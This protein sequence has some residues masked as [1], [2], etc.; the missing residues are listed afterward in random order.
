MPVD[1]TTKSEEMNFAAHLKPSDLRE[2]T[3]SYRDRLEDSAVE[4]ILALSTAFRRDNLINSE[5]NERV[6]YLF[7]KKRKKEAC[8]LLFGKV[9]TSG[10]NE[11]RNFWEIMER[12][13]KLNAT[14]NALINEIKRTAAGRCGVIRNMADDHDTKLKENTEYEE[15]TADNEKSRAAEDKHGAC[16]ERARDDIEI[17]NQ[18]PATDRRDEKSGTSQDGR[19]IGEVKEHH[20]TGNDLDRNKQQHMAVKEDGVDSSK[21]GGPDDVHSADNEGRCGVIR[22]MAGDADTELKEN[23]ENEED[24]VDNEKPRAAKAKDGA[25]TERA[26]EDI[27]ITNQ[28]PA[29]D[30]RDEKSGTSQD[31][32]NIGGRCG[33]IRKMADDPDT[34]LKENTE[35]EEDTVDNEKPRAA[36][37]KGGAGTER[38]REDI[39]I[40]NQVPA[41]E[42]RD[43]KSG[44]S[45]D[46]RTI[47]EVKEHYETGNDLDRTKLQHMAVKEDGADSSKSG[48]PEDVHSA[49]IEERCGVIR[50]MADDPNTEL[51]ENTENEEDTVDNEKPR[52]AKAKDGADTER[53][54]ED[55]EIT[56]QESGTD[57]R[58]EKSGTSQDGRTTGEAKEH[59]ETG[60]D[61]DRNKQQ[62]MALKEDG[63]DSS[64]SGGPEDLHSADNE[65]R[66]GVIRNIVEDHDTELKE[67]TENEEDTLDNEKPGAA[68]D[69]HSAG[70]ERAREDIEITNQES[71]TNRRDEKSGTSQDGRTRGDTP[72]EVEELRSNCND[73]DNNAKLEQDVDKD[74]VESQSLTVE[75]NDTDRKNVIANKR[76][77]IPTKALTETWMQ[78]LQERQRVNDVKRLHRYNLERQSRKVNLPKP[79]LIS[80]IYIEPTITMIES[81]HANLTG[82]THTHITEV[83][84]QELFK[85]SKSDS[86]KTT[87]SVIYGAAGTGKSTLIQKIIND[88]ARE[89]D[90][91]EFCFVLP[92]KIQNLNAIK[93]PLTLSRLILDSYPHFEDYLDHLWNEPK[94]LLFIFDD[95][96]QL[97]RLFALSDTGRNNNS[98]YSFTDTEITNTE[99]KYLVCDIVRCLLQGKFLRGCS[100]LI[101]TREWKLEL[102]NHV[103]A[104]STFEFMGFTSEKAKTYFRRY[105]GNGQNTNEI[106]DFIKQSDILWNMCSDPLF[107]VTLASSL[108]SFQAQGERNLIINHTM[109]LFDYVTHLFT[110]CGYDGSTNRK[111]LTAVGELAEKGIKENTL[112]FEGDAFRDL[113]SC[114]SMFISAFMYQGPDKQCGGAIYKFRHSVLRDFLAA[115]ANVLNAPISRLKQILDER[116]TDITGRFSTFLIFLVGLSSRKSTD[117]L[118]LELQTFPTEVTSCISEWLRKIVTRRLK[119]LDTNHTQRMF[120]CILYCLLEFRDDEIM[121]EVL[122]PIT[123]I[124]LNHLRLKSPDCIILSRTLIYPEVIQE[125]DL[126]SCFAQPEDIRKLEQV[127]PRCVNLRLNQNNL[128]DSG[129]KRLFDVLKKSKIKTLALKSNHLTDNCLESVFF[130]LTTNPSLMQ[131]NLSN[132]SQDGKEDNKFTDEKLQYYYER[133]AQQKEIKWQ[134]IKHIVQSVTESNC[135]TL[136]TE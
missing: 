93:S 21:S 27:E 58:D 19:T 50:N 109:V 6:M 11:V 34:E 102:L 46:S 38:A 124:K 106:V 16:T 31:G 14:L 105:L 85:L 100:V 98:R 103:T 49:D 129:V 40:T 87:I 107:C 92:F 60:N 25:G 18:D 136:I 114:T 3:N 133:S 9:L 75:Q 81:E 66:C 12:H 65:G 104:D 91:Q 36:E 63:V 29:N 118:E 79:C 120:L 30:R 80:D 135:L 73:S 97:Y 88:W 64:K 7:K 24:T 70:T 26:R 54:R 110:K 8:K 108:E 2:I 95:L 125:L 123:T 48:G 39:E 119:D 28:D 77:D 82:G 37:A 23:T 42:R 126:S 1:K 32:R 112:S 15:D 131:L 99:S 44:T 101:T 13:Q 61:L 43:E 53:A 116:S 69:K 5:E 83:E 22:N 55:I 35:N 17:T 128:Q 90:F 94:R 96:D 51:K 33:A 68:E 45:Q 132:S 115:L 86:E 20:E 117:R 134:R 111:Y 10:D 76:D 67:N 72:K 84:Y 74:N 4:Y 62:H 89:V 113:D 52:A 122:I 127:L 47:G 121:K 78:I 59:H 41:T 56:N 57:R 71:G 130:A